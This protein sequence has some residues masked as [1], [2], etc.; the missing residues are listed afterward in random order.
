MLSAAPVVREQWRIHDSLRS[1]Q[2]AR[3]Q[4]CVELAHLAFAQLCMQGAQSRPTLGN[5][6]ATAG[7]AIQPVH[8]FQIRIAAPG[9]Q[10]L[11]GALPDT[12]APVHREARRLLA[13]RN[14][15][16]ATLLTVVDDH[17]EAVRDAALA[18]LMWRGV[19]IPTSA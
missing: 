19:P 5:E 17:D 15:T 9:T 7:I 16:T 18:T 13:R 10:H 12:A 6:Q 11:D 14:L 8:E 4:G 3:Q 2:P 1:L